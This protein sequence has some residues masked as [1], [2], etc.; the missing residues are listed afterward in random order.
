[1]ILYI[2]S[3]LTHTYMRAHT[4]THV[5]THKRARARVFNYYY[6]NN[7][8]IFSKKEEIIKYLTSILYIYPFYSSFIL[9]IRHKKAVYFKK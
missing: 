5:H 2:L 1:M 8:K 3:I 4:R 9:R 7:N 6:R